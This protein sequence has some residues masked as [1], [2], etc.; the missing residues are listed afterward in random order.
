MTSWW[1]FLAFGAALASALAA[2]IVRCCSR[3]RRDRIELPKYRMLEE[4]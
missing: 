3:R 1:I 2:V 4:D